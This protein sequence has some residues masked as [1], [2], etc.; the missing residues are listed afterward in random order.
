M[1]IT[2]TS[3]VGID[4]RIQKFQTLL[5]DR[6]MTVWGLDKNDSTENKLYEC[7]GRCYRNRKD[8][9]Y[10]AE[11]Y[12]SSNQYKDVYWN[13]AKYAISFFGTSNEVKQDVNTK[14][15][16]HLVF[17]VNIKKL[18]PSIAHR[19]DEEV[20]QDVIEIASKSNFGFSFT[21]CETGVENVLRE[22][23]GTY[24]D[25]RLKYVDM[26]PV[27]CFRLNFSLSYNKKTNC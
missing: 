25:E 12:T 10:V 4:V 5:H 22:Y 20:R 8:T 11:V 17:F 16:V 2:K 19:G 27:H 24:R 23:P 6:L 14:A 9:G 1:L 18:K 21:S 15:D 26:H 13:D 7:Y 3:P